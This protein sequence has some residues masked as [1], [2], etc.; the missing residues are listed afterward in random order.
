MAVTRQRCSAL[1]LVFLYR[2][3]SL[4]HALAFLSGHYFGSPLRFWRSIANTNPLPSQPDSCV[5]GTD[6]MAGQ[7]SAP[8]LHA[9]TST[10]QR[11]SPRT[12]RACASTLSQARTA[13]QNSRT[14]PAQPPLRRLL[15]VRC[16]LLP[17]RPAW[18]ALASARSCSKRSCVSSS[19]ASSLSLRLLASYMPHVSTPVTQE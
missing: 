12:Q 1:P 9:Q 4:L 18:S 3:T 5:A 16:Y 19:S 7:G 10:R 17:K 13:Q 2:L 14:D 11:R 15:L 6:S 8:A